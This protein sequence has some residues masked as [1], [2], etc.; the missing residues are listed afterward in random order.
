MPFLLLFLYPSSCFAYI[1]PL[2]LPQPNI[3]V[4]LTRV[5]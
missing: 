1:L 3:S 5:S 2:R 4:Q